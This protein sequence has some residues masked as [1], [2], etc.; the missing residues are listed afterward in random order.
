MVTMNENGFEICVAMDVAH[1]EL[2]SSSHC[3]SSGPM[4]LKD[5]S[6]H[7]TI[8]KPPQTADRVRGPIQQAVNKL[9]PT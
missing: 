9:Q 4:V 5:A 7:C 8:W 6:D 3:L 2:S 1:N